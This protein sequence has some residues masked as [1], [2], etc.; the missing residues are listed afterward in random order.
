MQI[1]QMRWTPST[2]WQ[3]LKSD[4][5]TPK[6][7]QLV[8]VFADPNCIDN[9]I[10]LG[11][12]KLRYPAAH[13]VGCSGA[14]NIL[15]SEISDDDIVA[16]AIFFEKSRIAVK[17][18]EADASEDISSL[19]ANMA[20]Q[21][22]SDDLRHFFVLA[23]GL[24]FNGSD[25]AK[26]VNVDK[27]VPVIGGLAGDNKRF[28]QTFVIADGPAKSNQIVLVAFYGKDLRVKC[29]CFAGWSEFGVNRAITKSTGNVVYEIDHQPALQLYKAYLGDMAKELPGSGLRF[30][31]SIKN[32]DGV[33]LIRTMLSVDEPS[34]S[35]TFAGN[36]PEGS[37]VLLMKGNTD[38]LVQGAEKA[39]KQ[40]HSEGNGLAIIISCVGR[41]M[42]MD[43]LSDSELEVM[44]ESLGDNVALT[45][46]YSYGE[47]APYSRDFWQC[48]L[49]NQTMTLFSLHEK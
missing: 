24:N 48:Q 1:E 41:R 9:N 22:L 15:G 26:G 11:D 42:L 29:G 23:D 8:L 32:S 31:L 30:P 37:V 39:A 4:L 27:N 17:V 2:D 38:D 5:A 7:A 13:I 36:V 18:I 46:F 44:Q 10:A 34:Q 20:K 14:G 25:I 6:A 43:Q 35:L 47:L 33:P 12:L 19:V 45:G 40:A 49:H 21:L 3:T 16:T 28:Q